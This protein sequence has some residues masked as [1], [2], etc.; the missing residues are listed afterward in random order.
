AV[1]SWP[2]RVHAGDRALGALLS[3][4]HRHLPAP[5]PPSAR[6]RATQPAAD[7]AAVPRDRVRLAV[8]QR[9]AAGARGPLAGALRPRQPRAAGVAAALVPRVHR[10]ARAADP[11]PRHVGL[12]GRPGWSLL[13]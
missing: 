9:R 3:L 8:R 13:A 7:V 4:R 11:R 10:P 5:Q 1:A 6:A 12:A 2:E